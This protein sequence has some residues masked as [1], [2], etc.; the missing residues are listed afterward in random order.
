MP[1]EPTTP[2]A[3]QAQ[4]ADKVETYVRHLEHLV[5][6]FN[7]RALEIGLGVRLDATRAINAG[8]S[9]S[10]IAKIFRFLERKDD[11]GVLHDEQLRTAVDCV[12]QMLVEPK[13]NGLILGAMQSGKTTSSLALQFAGPVI[14][15]LTGRRMYPI[16]L[17]TSHTSQQDQT[18]IELQAFLEYYGDV[19][20]VIDEDRRCSLVDYAGDL[21]LDIVFLASSTLEAYR[22]HVL[23]NALPYVYTGPRPEDFIHRRVHGAGVR[24]IAE[25]CQSAHRQGFSPL[26]IIDE[27]QFGASDRMVVDEDG[28][29]ARRAC[30]MTQIFE[31]IEEELGDDAHD[32]VFVGLS[33]T[34]YELIDLERVWVV[35][36]YLSPNYVGFNF[37]V[38]DTID[39]AVVTKPPTTLGFTE[40]GARYKLPFFGKVDLAAYDASPAGFQRFAKK[41]GYTRSQDAYRVEVETTLRAAIYQMAEQRRGDEPV[42]ICL[43]LFND[44][45]KSEAL[46]RRLALDPDRIDVVTWYGAESKGQ[47]VKRAIAARTRKDLPFVILVTNR[48]R[49]GDAFPR[50]VEWFVDF[51]RKASDLNALLQGLLGRACGY[52]KNSTVVLSDDNAALVVDY[53]A[54]SGG[55]IYKPSR[56]SEIIGDYRRGAPTSLVRV[57]RDMVDP[58]VRQFFARLDAEVLA[59]Q[60]SQ[61]SPVLRT[62]RTRPYRTGPILR[63]AEELRL[64]EHLEDGEVRARLLPTM[65]GEMRLAR[66]GDVVERARAGAK[67]LSYT[68]DADGNCRFTFRRDNGDSEAHSGLQSRGY[69]KRDSADRARAGDSLEPQ[70][71]V[72]K[73]D[74]DTRLPINDA[75]LER[76][77]QATGDWESSMVVFP[78]ARP[79]RELRAGD[80]TMPVAASPFAREMTDEERRAAG[81]D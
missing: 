69:G 50:Q 56:H 37:F 46:L 61:N 10:S 55:L 3:A 65:P 4:L 80:S 8:R 38:G 45:G 17:V 49:M 29:T 15:L 42:G 78:L 14:Y 20:V 54:T 67:P 58:V 36:Q 31:S 40:F 60:V 26:L 79:V 77:A 52:N 75:T 18:E 13:R 62:T 33:A 81:R 72:R 44:N 35:K 27:P 70:V 22:T 59:K 64:F 1:S 63:I 5:Q 74:P 34:P 16:Y 28:N 6:V 21:K 25:L 76:D 30:V 24:R 43:R 12:A 7:A 66:A 41:H 39:E 48:A 32:H 9:F 23:R 2:A 53:K 73:V 11:S 57:K 71:Y 19:E 47:S 68:I 51:S